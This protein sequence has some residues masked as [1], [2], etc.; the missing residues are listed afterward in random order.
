MT[1]FSLVLNLPPWVVWPWFVCGLVVTGFLVWR[2]E[3]RKLEANRAPSTPIIKLD[4][5]DVEGR[6][7]LEQARE[8][9][10]SLKNILGP[11]EVSDRQL[12]ILKRH[13]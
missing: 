1:L 8:E 12:A 7:E 9:I 3:H 5:A 4:V 13:L 11:R 2:D 10:S 6:K